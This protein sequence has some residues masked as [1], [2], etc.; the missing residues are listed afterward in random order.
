MDAVRPK[1]TVKQKARPWV[2]E[3]ERRSETPSVRLL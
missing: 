2:R 3:T 1:E